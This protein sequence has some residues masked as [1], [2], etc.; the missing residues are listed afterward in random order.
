MAIDLAA[1][2]LE[3]L[4]T[5]EVLDRQRRSQNALDGV[6]SLQVERS[7]YT[8][9]RQGGSLDLSLR[10]LD[11]DLLKVSIRPWVT[12][13]LAGH[14]DE[15]YPMM[16]A[17]PQL[18]S[19]EKRSSASAKL[20]LKLLDYTR[21][22]DVPLGKAFTANP[23]QLVTALVRSQLEA[24]GVYDAAITESSGTVSAGMYW[25]PTETRRRVVNDL[26]DAIG[27]G[28]IWAD[29][30]G[31]L[32]A[33]PYVRP[34]NRP[35]QGDLGFVHGRT[36]TYSPEFTIE[37]ELF[38]VPNHVVLTSRAEEDE[39]PLVAEAWL[40]AAHP[41]SVQNRA[42]LEIPFTEDGVDVAG[43]TVPAKQANLDALA[44]KRLNDRANPTRSFHVTNRWRP[45]ELQTVT[46]FV[47]PARHLSPG[48]DTTVSLVSDSVR[49]DAGGTLKTSSVLQEV[50]RG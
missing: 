14:P 40:P 19:P 10:Q 4:V 31:Q 38:D 16:T 24:V 1:S 45:L 41:N 49:Y 6:Q 12:L 50:F 39:E 17:L 43:D 46:R 20:S 15:H 7:I 9:P 25:A 32:H 34:A 29:S 27:Y 37:H 21:L 36:C 5:F 22:L 28:A 30:W 13:R 26:L 11:V 3:Q 44:Q 2:G 23:G 42:G 18:V 33:E 47:A 8:T 48:Y 35:V